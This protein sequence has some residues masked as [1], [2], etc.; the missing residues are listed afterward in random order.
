MDNYFEPVLI[1]QLKLIISDET[2]D[3]DDHFSI[4]IQA[5]HLLELA[6]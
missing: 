5:C 4:W 3:L 6:S 2:G 1:K